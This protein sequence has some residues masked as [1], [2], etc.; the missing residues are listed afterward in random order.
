MAL[1]TKYTTKPQNLPFG[2]M[3]KDKEIY[4]LK[5]RINELEN[6][7]RELKGIPMIVDY[8]DLIVAM[9]RATGV[10]EAEIMGRSRIRDIVVCRQLLG[11]Y[12]RMGLG[13]PYNE[14]GKV[15]KRHHS[16]IIHSVKLVE[17]WLLYPKIYIFENKLLNQ[18]N[19]V[20][21]F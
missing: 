14:C 20:K 1:M 19:Y 6:E 17:D 13:L 21:H 2:A 16:S 11:H 3:D 18:I 8:Q 7:I 9:I 4:Y 10:T 15:L 5:S 12:L